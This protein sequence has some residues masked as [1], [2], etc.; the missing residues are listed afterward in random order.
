MRTVHARPVT[1]DLKT[2]QEVFDLDENESEGT[3]KL[4]AMAGR[5]LGHSRKAGYWSSMNSMPACI[6]C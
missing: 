1:G 2:P 4:F 5:W 6:P 3:K